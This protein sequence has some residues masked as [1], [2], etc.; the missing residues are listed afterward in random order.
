MKRSEGNKRKNPLQRKVEKQAQQKKVSPDV[1]LK[2]CREKFSLDETASRL[3]V[4]TVSVA[5]YIERLLRKGDE[6]D[7]NCYVSPPKQT[8]IEEAFLTLRTSSVDR[9]ATYLKG[10]ATVEE[11]R[12]VRGYLQ[13]K[14]NSESRGE[15]C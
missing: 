14:Y 12:I 13:Y 8:D 6:I 15:F 9:V 4:S 1:V 10:S 11:I 7:V 2:L 5:I 3:G